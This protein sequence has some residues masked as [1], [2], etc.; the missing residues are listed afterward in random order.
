MSYYAKILPGKKERKKRHANPSCLLSSSFSFLQACS[1]TVQNGGNAHIRWIGR[2]DL[3]VPLLPWPPKSPDLTPCDFF[4]WGYVNDE[5]Y[6]PPMPTTLQALQERITAA[7][8]DIDGNMLLN[9]WT[10]LD[11]R[12]DVCRVTK[13]PHIELL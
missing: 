8:T 9:F 3:D 6:V 1:G 7:V 5:V 10:D 13:G 2:A 11:Y 12:W 4:L